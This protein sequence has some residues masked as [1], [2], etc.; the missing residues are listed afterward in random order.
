LAQDEAIERLQK[1]VLG[2][3]GHPNTGQLLSHLA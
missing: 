3:L 2:R 1:V